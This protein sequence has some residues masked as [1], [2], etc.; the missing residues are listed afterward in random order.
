MI[1]ATALSMARSLRRSAATRTSFALGCDAPPLG[2]PFGHN[3]P[4]ARGL[5]PSHTGCRP[6]ECSVRSASRRTPTLLRTHAR[7]HACRHTRAHASEHTRSPLPCICPS[8]ATVAAGPKAVLCS[9]ARR[10]APIRSY[11]IRSYPIRSNPIRSARM[12]MLAHTRACA[13]LIGFGVAFQGSRCGGTIAWPQ[14][15]DQ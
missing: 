3:L 1:T 7:T 2:R 5:P 12:R 11:L 15:T 10:R 6:R 14:P 9:A 4:S 13:A 8:L